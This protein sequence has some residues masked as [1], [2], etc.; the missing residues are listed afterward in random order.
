MN[1]EIFEINLK[2]FAG[3]GGAGAAGGRG[4]AAVG[5]P[6]GARGQCGPRP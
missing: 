5:L 3:S 4:P 1:L 6:A 2:I